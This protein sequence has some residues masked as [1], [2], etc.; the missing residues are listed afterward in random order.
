MKLN[1][2]HIIYTIAGILL[3][4]A[5]SSCADDQPIA[6]V[7]AGDIV[8]SVKSTG[9][10]TRAV[11]DDNN[12]E[13]KI[14]N[15]L[16]LFARE[17]ASDDEPAVIYSK[18]GLSNTAEYTTS[19]TFTREERENLFKAV[20]KG[21]KCRMYVLVNYAGDISKIKSIADAKALQVTSEFDKNQEQPNFVMEGEGEVEITDG[22]NY[23]GIGTVEVTRLASRF[24]LNV[25]VKKDGTD[26]DYI[27]DV[28]GAKWYPVRSN[29]IVCINDAQKKAKISDKIETLATDP[30]GY[31]Q[32]T[33]S[34]NTHTLLTVGADNVARHSLPIYTYMNKWDTYN[35]KNMTYFIVQLPWRK[36]NETSYRYCYYQ[37]PATTKGKIDRN[38]AYT[39]NLN[40]GMLGS[41]DE[42]K[43]FEIEDLEYS[44]IPWNSIDIGAEMTDINYLV[45]NQTEA[46]FYNETEFSIPFFSTDD[47]EVIDISMSYPVF[48]M[49]GSGGP[50]AGQWKTMTISKTQNDNSESYGGKVFDY[51]ISKD[52]STTNGYILNITHALKEYVAYSVNNRGVASIV[53]KSS[54]TNDIDGY[55]AAANHWQQS[56]LDAYSIFTFTVTIQHK[57]GDN[58]ENF[59]ET[60][61]I[62][63]YPS[64]YITS[65]WN[66]NNG[67]YT[68]KYYNNNSTNTSNQTNT[69]QKG[70]VLINSGFL[71]S[72][73]TQ[74]YSCK[75]GQENTNGTYSSLNQLPT[76]F[77]TNMS[78]SALGTGTNNNNPNIY[79]I[80][81]SKLSEEDKLSDGGTYNLG[82]SRQSSVTVPSLTGSQYWAYAPTTVSSEGNRI[83]KNYY[84]TDDTNKYNISPGFKIASSYGKTQ[85]LSYDEAIKRCATYQEAGYPAGRWRVPTTS[86]VAYIV[87]LAS[88]G[89][90][91][92]LFGLDSQYWTASGFITPTKKNTNGYTFSDSKTTNSDTWVR[93]VYDEW[94]WGNEKVDL[95]T[96]TWGDEPRSQASGAPR[97]V[98]TKK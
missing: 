5:L 1:I 76:I 77:G 88:I 44:I 39:I 31:F 57:T 34:Y 38:F 91:P 96:F 61:K 6:E 75:A 8:L 19:I 78:A 47:V 50:T 53:E 54:Y 16:F 36:E 62:Y 51:S 14:S 40:I 43:P 29:I 81:I 52:P 97:R 15:V 66:S 23:K 56:G 20:T 22:D 90:I 58:K 93:C 21:A 73:G 46:S 89:I 26:V 28:N 24:N 11:A 4:G 92:E 60:I 74:R 30:T 86:E 80:H 82:D 9:P 70:Y 42:A 33:P 13:N 65:E 71:N 25:T 68:A 41:F 64:M 49:S 37:I 85:S 45:V 7:T 48:N 12:N 2:R 72:S 3:S 79:T 27:T 35:P 10:N 55:I 32:T 87:K 94:Y 83:L 67:T 59:T 84:P 95:A 63:Q 18:P 17:D 69:P 98:T